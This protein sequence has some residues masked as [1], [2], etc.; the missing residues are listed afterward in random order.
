V[1]FG[2]VPKALTLSTKP[3]C[4]P[5]TVLSFFIK[6]ATFYAAYYLTIDTESEQNFNKSGTIY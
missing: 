2:E 1:Y 4:N 5:Y 3:S 6:S